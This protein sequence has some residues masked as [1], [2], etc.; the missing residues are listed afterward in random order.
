MESEA[1]DLTDSSIRGFRPERVHDQYLVSGTT[2]R[3]VNHATD[4]CVWRDVGRIRAL[5]RFNASSSTRFTL[6]D[7]AN[8]SS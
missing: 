6:H 3:S 2:Q 8:S 5:A 1:T 7:R 4:Q